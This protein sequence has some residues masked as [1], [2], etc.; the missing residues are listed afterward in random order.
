[1][2]QRYM[3]LFY[4]FSMHFKMLPFEIENLILDYHASHNTWLLKRKL[5]AQLRIFFVYR[6]FEV[7]VRYARRWYVELYTDN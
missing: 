3:K 2:W 6:R 1:M 7:A 5:H 4:N